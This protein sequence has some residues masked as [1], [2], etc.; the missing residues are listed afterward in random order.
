MSLLSQN[1]VSLALSAILGFF[2]LPQ[3]LK[4]CIMGLSLHKEMQTIW[5]KWVDFF[6]FS[7]KILK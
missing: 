3:S 1:H 7:I 6:F 5:S 2:S 4:Q